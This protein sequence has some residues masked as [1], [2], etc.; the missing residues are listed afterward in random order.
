[1]AYGVKYRLIFSDL[2]GNG[3]KVEILQDGY[4]GEVLPM[5]GTGDPVQIEWEGDDDFYQPIIG[6][7]CTINLLVT[8]DVSYDDFFKGN[9]E[10]Y[11]VQVYYDRGTTDS[12][13]D[14]VEAFAT[15]AGYFE[16]PDCISDTLSQNNT[17][18]SDFTKRVLNDGGT[19]DNETCIAKSIT[20]S[21]TYDWQTLWEGFLYLDTYSE[22]LATT[23][24]EISITALDGLGLLDVENTRA[25]N[26]N[27][28][29]GLTYANEGEW[30]FVSEMLQKFNVDETATNERQL[31]WGILEQYGTESF[32]NRTPARPWS[33]YSNID[34]DYNFLNEKDVLENI[35]RKSNSRIF[36]AFGDWY[37]VPNSIYLDEVFSSQY[38]DRSVFKNALVNGQNEIINFEVFG[39]GASRDLVGYSTRNVTR[40]MK[41]DLQ[42]LGNDLSIEYLSPLKKVILNSDLFKLSELRSSYNTKGVGFTYGS[43]GYILTYGTVGEN[44]FVTSNNQSYRVSNFVTNPSSRTQML[45]AGTTPFNDF[46]WITSG[47]SKGA[48]L[49]FNF[50]F[51]STATSPNYK[52]YYS[53]KIEYGISGFRVTEYYDE[54]NKSWSSTIVYNVVEFND[55]EE[56]QRWQKKDVNITE[57]GVIDASIDLIFY[58]PY[59]PSS[60]GYNALYLDDIYLKSN[61]FDSKEKTITGTISE[62]RGKY[63]LETIPNAEIV[64]SFFTNSFQYM[65][66]DDDSNNI[67][68]ILNDYRSYV[69]RYEGTG[70]GLKKKPV[71]PID[72]LYMDFDNFKE[73]QASMIDTLKYNLR[74]N[75]SEF[76][77][78]TPNNDP[79]VSV[80]EQIKEVSQ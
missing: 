45:D 15:N 32:G 29:P 12:F 35:L 6:S 72:K 9:E 36:H 13:Q 20:N 77:A 62:N 34:S 57:I 17:I 21:K 46:S 75:E 2:L 59:V 40:R 11:R 25:L 8:D 3:K 74:R 49:F 71:T 55:A 76:V 60:S 39:V 19:I 4:S 68:Q 54:E 52:F 70:Y 31:Y 69:P 42:P 5:I 65:S 78:H 79:D 26:N 16:S 67:Q 44:D 73:D 63:E 50:L 33:I 64:N 51:D 18:S 41:K 53:L 37:V 66:E 28:A 38:Y 61:N 58:L 22:A 23:P 10:E 43:N 30:Y 24:Y 80:T 14:R 7:S 56:L 1:M 48:T 27:V 47:D